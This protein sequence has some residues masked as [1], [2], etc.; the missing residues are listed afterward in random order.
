[1]VPLVIA[2]AAV[3]PLNLLGTPNVIEDTFFSELA[4][5]FN[6][7]PISAFEAD[8]IPERGSICESSPFFCMLSALLSNAT[9]S[10]NTNP[11]FGTASSFLKSIEHS[12]LLFN[13]LPGPSSTEFLSTIPPVCSSSCWASRLGDFFIGEC[14][15]EAKLCRNWSLSTADT[16]LPLDG[17]T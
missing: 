6:F 8:Q 11:V 4:S 3:T 17:C 13:L 5:D 2:G 1:M 16:H 9:P 7:E 14:C 10:C 12:L 15:G